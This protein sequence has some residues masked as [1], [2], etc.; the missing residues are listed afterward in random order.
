MRN[1]SDPKFIDGDYATGVSAAG[2]TQGTATT[3][4]ANHC[5]VTVVTDS[6]NGVILKAMPVGEVFSVAN[7]DGAGAV[8]AQ[9]LKVYPPVG[10]SFNGMTVN[11]PITLPPGFGA[12]G[13]FVSSTAIMVTF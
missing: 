9:A 1:L 10:S 5:L 2:T 3:L 6:A 7:G 4:A 11:D 8:G 13:R 12:F